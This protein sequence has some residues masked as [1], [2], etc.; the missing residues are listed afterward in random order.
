MSFRAALVQM[1]VAGGDKLRNLS[2]AEDLIGQ[3]AV[4]GAELVLLPEAM[5]LGWTDSSS[6]KGAE[7]IPSGTPCRRL[8]EAAAKHGVFVCSGLTERNGNQIFN[9]AVLLD[10]NGTL[11]CKHRKINELS[12]GHEYYALGDRLN[13]ISTD[14]GAI[15]LMIC[16]D[17]FAKDRVLSRSL[18]YMGADVILSP[19]AWAVP[20]DHD[21]ATTPYGDTWREAYTPV[22]K[23]F[24]VWILGVSNVG[25]IQSG[26]WAGRR[27]IGCSLVIG[28]DGEEILQG[29]YGIDAETI[30]YVDVEP[31][32]RP[33]RGCGWTEHWLEGSSNLRV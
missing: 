5:D 6:Q 27:C 10:R 14:L 20:A 2:N 9:S 33:A 19:C 13:V 25:P 15:G 11:L 30:L 3:A 18:C 29:P 24:S 22:A 17:G 26:P 16:A 1:F 8:A 32:K 4:H 12:I 28:P 7:A 23:E 31:R 21:N